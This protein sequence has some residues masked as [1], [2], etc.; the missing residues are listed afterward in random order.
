MVRPAITRAA[1]HFA[2]M[3]L[4]VDR[5]NTY[6]VAGHFLF[7]SLALSE[8]WLAVSYRCLRNR[9]EEQLRIVQDGDHVA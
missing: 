5:V 1:M 4:G 3:V 2:D 9:F 7:C 6:G 8:P